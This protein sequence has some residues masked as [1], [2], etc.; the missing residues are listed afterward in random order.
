MKL[1]LEE[2]TKFNVKGILEQFG[3]NRRVGWGRRLTH[4]LRKIE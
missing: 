2:N 3:E 4:I 1:K